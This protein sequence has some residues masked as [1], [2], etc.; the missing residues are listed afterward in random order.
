MLLQ[1]ATTIRNYLTD[2][3]SG[4]AFQFCA[5]WLASKR[6]FS[7]F[8]LTCFAFNSPV[9]KVLFSTTAMCSTHSYDSA[10]VGIW[11]LSFDIEKESPMHGCYAVDVSAMFKLNVNPPRIIKC[12]RKG[13]K[14]SLT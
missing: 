3:N 2:S 11:A 12:W 13:S 6:F 7:H 8:A 9:S 14:E 1:L 10:F 5:S 4:I